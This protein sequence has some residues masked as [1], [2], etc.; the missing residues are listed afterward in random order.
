MLLFCTLPKAAK[1]CQHLPLTL[2]LC[3]QVR[4][5]QEKL[6]STSLVCRSSSEENL[7]LQQ[8]LQ[9]QQTMLT[10]STRRVSELE[11]SQSQL[12]TQVRKRKSPQL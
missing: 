5:L 9:E 12:H 4:S 8:T 11:E 7:K 3:F 2:A 6:H 10:E 1:S